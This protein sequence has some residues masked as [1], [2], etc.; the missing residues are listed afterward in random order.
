MNR[1]WRWSLAGTAFRTL[2]AALLVFGTGAGAF[3]GSCGNPVLNPIAKEFILSVEMGY[4]IRDMEA[5]GRQE[6]L[7]SYGMS[8]QGTYG[9]TSRLALFGR[10]GMSDLR[11]DRARFNGSLEPSFGG[12]LMVA[13]YRAERDPSLNIVLNGAYDRFKSSEGEIGLSANSYTGSVLMTKGVE[14]L[15]LY[16]GFRLSSIDLSGNGAIPSMDSRRVFGVVAGV[17]YG[18]SE[19]IYLA[20]ETHLFDQYAVLG[21]IGFNFGR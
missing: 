17:D 11:L 9:V 3:A 8:I 6:D 15:L 16:G 2:L 5:R 10:F 14:D 4:F 20:V 7:S 12:G 19:R 13:L 21:G 18:I 1:I